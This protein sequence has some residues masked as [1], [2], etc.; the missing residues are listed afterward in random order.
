MNVGKA[1]EQDFK[2]SVPCY[3]LLHRVSD[4]A[5]SFGGSNTL[6]FSNKSCFDFIMWDSELCILYALELK[7]VKGKSISFERTKEEKREIHYHQI[8]SLNE[9]A[10]YNVESGFIIEF[11]EISTTI[12]LPI[13]EFN[14]LITTID[15][16][17]FN[18]GDICDNDIDYIIIPQKIKR[19][20]YSYDVDCLMQRIRGRRKKE[21]KSKFTINNSLKLGDY[22]YLVNEI[23]DGY[24][25]FQGN[26]Q[27]HL[28]ILNT[29][30]IYYISCVVNSVYDE[31]VPHNVI[32]IADMQIVIEDEEFQACF[33][34]AIMPSDTYSITFGTAYKMAMDIVERKNYSISEGVNI[35]KNVILE[36]ADK[37]S[38]AFNDDTL[39]QLSTIAKEIDKGNLTPNAM[40]EAYSK[41]EAF[42]QVLDRADKRAKTAYK[43]KNKVKK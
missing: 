19:T 14:K 6:R 3:A 28:G 4:S 26:Y 25:D 35:V 42:K 7:T 23:A 9:W 34:E 22:I 41:S 11:R 43:L 17:S 29:M 21:M 15:K 18:Y 1:F 38:P 8:M 33:N 39:N 12:Y 10:K 30:R 5:T 37:I 13:E 40:W 27:P 32:D 20:R 24:F 2:K 36:I 31:K 16:F